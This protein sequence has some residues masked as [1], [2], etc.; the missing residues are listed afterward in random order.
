[1]ELFVIIG[2]IMVDY[3]LSYILVTIKQACVTY[4]H[5]HGLNGTLHH[6]T[7]HCNIHEEKFKV[8]H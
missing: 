1:M 4:H 8:G 3:A 6:M 5:P 7:I 2:L